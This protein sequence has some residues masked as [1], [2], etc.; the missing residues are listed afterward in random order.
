M[1]VITPNP[2]SRIQN[3]KK[4]YKTN[5]TSN[6]KTFKECQW[7]SIDD[8]GVLGE[9]FSNERTNEKVQKHVQ[10]HAGKK[11]KNNTDLAWIAR[12]KKKIELS[13]GGYTYGW[14]CYSTLK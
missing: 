6:F 4:K 9:G 12:N 2:I 11:K 5:G 8:I 10:K 13:D 14:E 7:V 1:A 3:N